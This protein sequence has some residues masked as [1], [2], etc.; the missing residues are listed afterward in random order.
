MVGQRGDVALQ[1]L[2]VRLHQLARLHLLLARLHR[3]H[4]KGD[5]ARQGDEAFAHVRGEIPLLTDLEQELLVAARF[6]LFVP[7]HVL[8]RFGD[9]HSGAFEVV[10]E[11]VHDRL[12]QADQHALARAGAARRLLEPLRKRLERLRLA[13]A[14]GDKHVAHENEGDR[15]QHR[16]VGVRPRHQRRGHEGGVAGV[17]EAAR[18]FDLGQLLAHRNVD[19]EHRLDRL[20]LVV[21][22]RNQI[23]PH[24]AGRKR[25][26][27]Q[28]AGRDEKAALVGVDMQHGGALERT[29][30]R[31]D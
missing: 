17:V 24:R 27:L 31:G 15:L 11:P 25:R 18:R 26:A 28:P 2:E 5:E 23:D 9:D 13:V 19:A 7:E 4:Q 16:L 22:G 12:E 6:S 30:A 3:R 10:G 8:G 1:R 20:L 29:D 21:G 14:H